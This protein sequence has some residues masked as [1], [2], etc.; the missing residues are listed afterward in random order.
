MSWRA[1]PE[2]EQRLAEP[3]DLGLEFKWLI[4]LK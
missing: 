2:K 3:W 4:L 1:G